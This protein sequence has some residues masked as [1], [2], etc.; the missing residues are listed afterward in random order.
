MCEHNRRRSRCVECQGTNVCLHK[1][2]RNTCVECKG[3]SMCIHDKRKGNCVECGGINMCI[4]RVRKSTCRKCGGSSICKH[5][6][7]RNKCRDC[8]K[9]HVFMCDSRAVVSTGS[10]PGYSW[11]L[12]QGS[13][14]PANGIEIHNDVLAAALLEKTE[15][16]NADLD[17]FG[18][19]FLYESYIKVGDQYYTPAAACL[20]CTRNERWARIQGGERRVHQWLGKQGVAL[21]KVPKPTAVRK[22]KETKV[23]EVLDSNDIV[24]LN[25]RREVNRD[26]SCENSSNRPD[27]QVR[28]AHAELLT[29]YIEVDEY[30]H[31]S[32]KSACELSRLNN[33]LACFEYQRHLVVIRYNPDPFTAG[34]KRMTCKELPLAEREKVLLR[35]LNRVKELAADPTNFKDIITVIHIAFDCDCCLERCASVRTT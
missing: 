8:P 28:H 33:L 25:D 12:I 24:H 1:T 3:N 32:I 14:E 22:K 26:S 2:Q 34:G 19:N 9:C 35:E 11:R 4:H 18:E 27:F 6:R 31:R 16:S 7:Q 29:I 17:S 15:F 13:L 30:Q 5:D 10:V 23:K 21:I 20:T